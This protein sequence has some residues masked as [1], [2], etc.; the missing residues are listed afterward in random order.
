MLEETAKICKDWFIANSIEIPKGVKEW[1]KG[2]SGITVP[3]K[4]TYQSLRDK[5]IN[6]GELIQLLN[7][8]YKN[9]VSNLQNDVDFIEKLGLQFLSISNKETIHFEC[10]NCK[11]ESS[12]LKGTLR[13]WESKNKKYCSICR[14]AP[15]K[16]KSIEYYQNFL[17]K[18][19]FLVLE[20]NDPLII[21]HTICGH[22][23]SR[24]RGYI[25]NSSARSSNSLVECPKCSEKNTFIYDRTQFNS[26][27]ESELI[28]ILMDKLS[29]YKIE[30]E[31]LYKNIFHTNR[32]FR[33]DI[34]IPNLRIGIEITSKN[35]NLPG[36]Q[37]NLQEKLEL[38][39]QNNITIFLV[40]SRKDIEDIVRTLS[41]DKES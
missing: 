31:V 27:T 17:D 32:S 10:L 37:N 34:W 29:S 18:S 24:C 41:K 39:K 8:S 20:N 22:R 11:N 5:N 15:G 40:T 23:F 2:R 35:N 28:P 4:C 36:Y 9:R 38:A 21:Q 3:P 30:R 19:Q 16:E 33:L 25:T 7:P 12:A 14:K 26:L 1:Q 6:V 13:R